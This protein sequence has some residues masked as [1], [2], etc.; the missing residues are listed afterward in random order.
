MMHG[1]S[2]ASDVIARHLARHD[3][4]DLD[5][6]IRLSSTDHPRFV[7]INRRIIE[8]AA[9]G[10]DAIG[11]PMG[12]TVAQVSIIDSVTRG[13][14]RLRTGWRGR[15]EGVVIPWADAVRFMTSAKTKRNRPK[16]G[17]R[18]E[19]E[20]IDRLRRLAAENPAIA[21]RDQSLRLDAGNPVST[22][23]RYR[24]SQAVL[25][26]RAARSTET[27]AGEDMLAQLLT[28]PGDTPP[29]D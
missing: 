25:V 4:H 17:S 1:T 9:S 12:W 3:A 15:A 10:R 20:A 16:P 7:T 28:K 21:A 24:E 22:P 14:R 19:A 29:W 6:Q 18:A 27:D 13:K 11:R 26:K 8:A 5:G 2:S 23:P